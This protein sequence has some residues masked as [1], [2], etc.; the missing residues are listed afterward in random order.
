MQD[1]GVINSFVLHPAEIE[2]IPYLIRP[3]PDPE[4]RAGFKWA[5]EMHK[6]LHPN[7]LQRS[8][9]DPYFL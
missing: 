2:K 9:D 3:A 1:I 5:Q 4:T 7:F 6:I 8:K